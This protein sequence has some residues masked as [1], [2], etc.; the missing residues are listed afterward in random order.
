MADEAELVAA[1]QAGVDD[2]FEQLV[3]RYG[4]RMLAVARRLVGEDDDA[5]DVVQ[6]AFLSAFRAIDRFEGTARLS[7]WLHRI[8]VNAALMRLRSRRRR[9]EKSLDVLLPHFEADGHMTSPGEPWQ[10]LA[11]LE[12]AELRTLVRERIDELP[13]SYR[14]VLLLRDIEEL[15]TGEVAVLL[16]VNTGTVKTRLH[17]ARLALRS[18]L[19]PQLR[20]S[21][22]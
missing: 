21:K 16:G 19:D 18:L 5:R 8:T 17:R 22:P 1:L 12:G 14:T 13:E 20:E 3:R 2:A 4:G 9:P 15:E 10:P 6:E 7:T 11:A